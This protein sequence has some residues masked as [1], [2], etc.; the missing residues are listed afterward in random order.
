MTDNAVVYPVMIRL[1]SGY[2]QCNIPSGDMVE[3]CTRQTPTASTAPDKEDNKLL[4][5]E[6]QLASDL[7]NKKFKTQSCPGSTN[8]SVILKQE[9]TAEF[10]EGLRLQEKSRLS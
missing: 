5:E 9:K 4:K 3:P 7:Q 8:R 1:F 10:L 2:L 6:M